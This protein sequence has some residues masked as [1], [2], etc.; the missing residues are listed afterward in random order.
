VRYPLTRNFWTGSTLVSDTCKLNQG[1]IT[2][3]FPVIVTCTVSPVPV[4]V[5]TCGAVSE[6]APVVAMN[7]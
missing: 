5:V 2:W 3:A 6:L 7:W 4:V 1:M